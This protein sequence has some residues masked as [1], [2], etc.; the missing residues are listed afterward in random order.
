MTVLS[1][2]DEMIMA[3][4]L[5]SYKERFEAMND[6]LNEIA[7]RIEFTQKEIELANIS[8]MKYKNMIYHIRKWKPLFNKIN[9]K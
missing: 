2:K 7:P 3:D 1:D 9:N 4:Y 5:R 6:L 8:D